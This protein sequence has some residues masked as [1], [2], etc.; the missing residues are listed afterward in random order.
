MCYHLSSFSAGNSLENFLLP[1][2]NIDDS[3]NVN[4]FASINSTNAI[5][6]YFC[7]VIL[8]LYVISGIVVEVKDRKYIKDLLLQ[9]TSLSQTA[10]D[11]I[12]SKFSIKV[13][14]EVVYSNLNKPNDEENNLPQGDFQYI[15]SEFLE[16]QVFIENQENQLF[17][18]NLEESKYYEDKTVYDINSP[19]ENR[20]ESEKKNGN[21]NKVASETNNNKTES[22]E[23]PQISPI[24]YEMIRLH[25]ILSIFYVYDP[26]YPRITRM[27]LEFVYTIGNMYF[28][29]LFYKGTEAVATNIS[30]VITSFV[31]N[32]LIIIVYSNV[33]MI[34]FILICRFIS[35]SQEIDVKEP[36]EAVLAVVKRNNKKKFIGLVIGWTVLGY[37]I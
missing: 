10:K 36:K 4:A 14:N 19:N 23:S 34:G 30:D 20:L 26:K 6:A 28:I 15:G 3:T 12:N 35:K 21:I 33:I 37:F 29:G 1:D 32:D 8:F 24:K 7:F 25:P 2:S 27:T 31:Y 17:I 13:E 22:L 16:N 9:N 11:V 18:E 5:G